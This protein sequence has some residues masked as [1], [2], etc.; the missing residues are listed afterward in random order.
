MAWLKKLANWAVRLID[1]SFPSGEERSSASEAPGARQAT[2]PDVFMLISKLEKHGAEYVLVGGYAL[3]FNG[4]VRQTGDIDIVVRNS[5]TNN[6]R[7][8]A[9][10][11][12]LPAGAAKELMQDADD[13]FPQETDPA[14]GEA[15]PGVIRVADEF[16][17]DVM[18]KACGLTFDDLKPFT[19]RVQ[20]KG[21][22]INVLDLR[23]LRATKQTT[24]A[25]DMEDLRHIEAALAALRGQVADH[26]TSMARRDFAKEPSP[27]AR[28]IEPR[29]DVETDPGYERRLDLA[30]RIIARATRD[31]A[32][33]ATDADGLATYGDEDTLSKLLQHQGTI[34][35]LDALARELGIDLPKL[36]S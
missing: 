24:R 5:P 23:G 13:P 34:S 33:I 18:P 30:T 26:V 28:G 36:T 21:Q 29:L 2:W 12:E 19:K 20:H 10:L 22:S 7:W 27:P 1:L 9:A 11:S 32:S 31:G 6:R 14:T 3:A 17:V 16:I 35:D 8:I 25:R 15:E 4:L